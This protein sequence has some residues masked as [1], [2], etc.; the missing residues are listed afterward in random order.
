MYPKD[1]AHLI[2][3]FISPWTLFSS[4]ASRSNFLRRHLCWSHLLIYLSFITAALLHP[5]HAPGV[6][7]GRS[8]YPCPFVFYLYPAGIGVVNLLTKNR[9]YNTINLYHPKAT[10]LPD[11]LS[12]DLVPT[13]ISFIVLQRNTPF[14]T[15]SKMHKFNKIWVKL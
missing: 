15:F 13:W 4:A 10:F 7:L 9:Q 1:G 8:L 3:N 5:S 12:Q 14:C 2:F 6:G 11:F